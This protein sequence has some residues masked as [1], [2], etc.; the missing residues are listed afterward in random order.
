[1]S[2]IRLL[3]TVFFLFV[4]GRGVCQTQPLFPS[5]TDSTEIEWCKYHPVPPNTSGFKSILPNPAPP[6]SQLTCG[7]I[8]VTFMDIVNSTGAGFDDP[9]LGATRISCLCAT[10][11]Y[12]QSVISFPSTI[13]ASNPVD[14]LFNVSLNTATNPALGFASPIFP[15]AFMSN[16]PGYYGGYLYDYITTGVNP[17]PVN[18]EHGQITM[19][20]G[21]SYNYCSS[22]IGNCEF[23]FQSVILHEF[24]HL[25]GVGSL[26]TQNTSNLL[27][28]LQA[29]NVFSQWDKV[30][31]YYYNGSAFNKIVDINSFSSNG[32]INPSVPANLFSNWTI[33]NRVW[34]NN[35]P[36][37]NHLNQPVWCNGLNGF[38]P[39]TTLS[40]VKKLSYLELPFHQAFLQ[41]ML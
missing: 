24:T 4:L 7:V 6:G 22:N 23:D 14:I 36:F 27:Q 21:H 29:P 5:V 33:M 12:I 17:A 19:N 3:L 34:L 32:G 2:Q 26:L 16:V 39:G 35:Q 40:H 15:P 20:F 13:T 37:S 18:Q 11:N 8:R 30:F 10:L 28:S 1:M 41:I 38:A 25:L 9:T 31:L